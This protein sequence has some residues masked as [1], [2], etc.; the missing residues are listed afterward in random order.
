[1]YISVWSVRAMSYPLHRIEFGLL[2]Y[3]LILSKKHPH[4]QLCKFPMGPISKSMHNPEKRIEPVGNH[5][6][7]LST[8]HLG[9]KKL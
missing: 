3:F 6:R 7:M 2:K 1:M 8:Q 4:T 9:R 5:N